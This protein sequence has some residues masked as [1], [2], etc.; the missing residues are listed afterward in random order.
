M[1]DN[2]AATTGDAAVA[3]EA[4]EHRRDLARSRND[5]YLAPYAGTLNTLGRLL[6]DDDPGAARRHLL[7]ARSRLEALNHRH[8]GHF[9][10]ELDVVAGNL[11]ALEG[12]A[13]G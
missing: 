3:I 9:D 12:T 10:R 5:A 2:L 11:E 8:P 1:L 4:L 6:L 13:D 7:E